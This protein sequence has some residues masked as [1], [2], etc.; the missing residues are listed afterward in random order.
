MLRLSGTLASFLQV[1]R[2]INHLTAGEQAQHTVQAG[3]RAGRTF[4]QVTSSSSTP[5]RLLPHNGLYRQRKFIHRASAEHQRQHQRKLLVWPFQWCPPGFALGR[6]TRIPG[7]SEDKRPLQLSDTRSRSAALPTTWVRTRRRC[8]CGGRSRRTRCTSPQ[9][10][11]AGSSGNRQI[12]GG[13]KH[14]EMP[15]PPKKGLST[16]W[17]GKRQLAVY[18]EIQKKEQAA[19]KGFFKKWFRFTPR[20]L[21]L[22]KV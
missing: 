22:V 4:S 18:E 7:W 15:G 10:Q 11:T 17:T 8:S 1:R 2:R 14:P 13:S 5:A 21:L 20:F 9:P 6:R 16:R 12:P 3:A 19:S